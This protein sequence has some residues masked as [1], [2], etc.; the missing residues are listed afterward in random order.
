MEA[1]EFPRAFLRGAIFPNTLKARFA[2]KLKSSVH[3]YAFHFQLPFSGKELFPPFYLYL[4]NFSP[5]EF[6]VASRALDVPITLG[7]KIQ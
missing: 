7:E 6:E 4:D 2:R 5:P 3:R 1:L